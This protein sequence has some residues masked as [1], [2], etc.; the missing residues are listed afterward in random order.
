MNNFNNLVAVAASFSAAPSPR[1]DAD[2]F[3]Y[4]VSA[5]GQARASLAFERDRGPGF[6]PRSR[7]PADRA[8]GDQSARRRTGQATPG[9]LPLALASPASVEGRW[10]AAPEG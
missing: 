9:N 4:S 6:G 8:C 3:W 1:R 5:G 7:E 10:S 2:A